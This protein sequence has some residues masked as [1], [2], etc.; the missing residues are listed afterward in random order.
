MSQSNEP[1]ALTFWEHL[2]VLRA[3]LL[4]MLAVAAIC[5]LVAF[6][7]KEQLF[8]LVLAPCSPSFV[9]YRLLGAEPFTIRLINV[10]LTEQFAVHVKTALVVGCYA[11]SPYIIYLLYQ[12]VAPGL[13]QRERHYTVRIVSAG[14]LMFMLGTVANY[15]LIFPLTVRFLG[16]YQVSTMVSNMLSLQ[17]YIDTFL[18]MS[19]VFGLLFEIPVVSWLLALGGLLRPEWMSRYRRHAIVAILIVAAVV[20][21]TGDAFTLT[22]VSL[23]I[24]LLYEVSVWIVKATYNT[25]KHQ[26]S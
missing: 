22:V 15:L 14:Y 2:D 19:V 3:D 9:T 13:Y 16:T 21:P 17:S 12:F 4:R 11:A 5:A 20:T 6:C 18:T 10:G 26:L 8:A 23:P 1:E 25:H 7:M 24:W